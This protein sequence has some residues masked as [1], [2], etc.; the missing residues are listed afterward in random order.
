ML[1]GTLRL[2][3]LI[4]GPPVVW[5]GVLTCLRLRL[6]ALPSPPLPRPV[7]NPRPRH[8]VGTSRTG[9]GAGDGAR[10]L[11]SGEVGWY[12]CSWSCH[13]FNASSLWG[14]AFSVEREEGLVIPSASVPRRASAEE[15]KMQLQLLLCASML[16]TALIALEEG[17]HPPSVDQKAEAQI[18]IC[19]GP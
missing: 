11:P 18:N 13:A 10:L 15:L 6:W 2:C 7:P 4:T 14:L 3:V 5:L 1:A 8:T 12:L 19:L 9:S 16:P 17:L